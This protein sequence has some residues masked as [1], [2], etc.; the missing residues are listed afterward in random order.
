VDH[1]R[2]ID[3][4]KRQIK[5]LRR[6]LREQGELLDTLASPPWKRIWFFLQ[7]YRLWR[8]GRWYR[9]TRDLK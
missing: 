6:E 4:L 8:V 1:E 5:S 3:L 2:E 7:G 9:K